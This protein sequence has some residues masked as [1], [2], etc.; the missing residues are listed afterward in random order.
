ML[1]NIARIPEEGLRLTEE[2]PSEILEL[3]ESGDFRPSGPIG[4]DVFVQF[5][6]GGLLVKGTLRVPMEVRCARC[7]QIYSTT[8]VDSGFLRD[9]PGVQPTEEV[10]ITED[11]R[12][13]VLLHLPHFPLCGEGCKGLCPHCGK[14]RNEGP[15]GCAAAA[16]SGSWKALDNL[17]L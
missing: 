12:E 9:F 8:V 3:D 10:D 17:N 13:A 11:I 1:I 14:S 16:D 4:C 15:C 6:S 2:E 7:A 5:V